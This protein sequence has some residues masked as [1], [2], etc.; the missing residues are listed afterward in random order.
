MKRQWQETSRGFIR[1]RE[2]GTIERH[3]YKYIAH[4]RF[5]FR[6]TYDPDTGACISVEPHEQKAHVL[7]ESATGAIKAVNVGFSQH[8]E[9]TGE[10][11]FAVPPGH[12]AATLKA[13]SRCKHCGGVKNHTDAL[14]DDFMFPVSLPE[15]ATVNL[16][17]Y[18]WLSGKLVKR[19]AAELQAEASEI[20]SRVNA[21]IVAQGSETK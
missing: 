6:A 7:V 5:T 12:E 4:D 10:P 8:H 1:E 19:D 20:L 16:I 11:P 18:R 9:L 3:P 14:P 2:D 15:Q 13:S 21:A 17:A